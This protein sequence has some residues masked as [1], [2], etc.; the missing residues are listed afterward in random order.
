MSVT[1]FKTKILTAFKNEIKVFVDS[2]VPCDEYL[3]E[4]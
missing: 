3:Y 4:F 2:Q 1:E